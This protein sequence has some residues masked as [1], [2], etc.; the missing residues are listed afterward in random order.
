M[1]RA[2][3]PA[4]AGHLGEQVEGDREGRRGRRRTDGALAHPEGQD[5]GHREAAGVAQQLGDEQE[6]DQPRDQEADRVEAAVVAVQRDGA[7]DAGN[8]AADR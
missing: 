8:E 1:S 5:V 4:D 2:T 6:R 3:S 7:G